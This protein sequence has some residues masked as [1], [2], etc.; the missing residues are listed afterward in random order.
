MSHT[1]I[2][3]YSGLYF[4]FTNPRAED[5]CIEDIARAL[6]MTPRFGGH[7]TSFYSVAEHSVLVR[8]LVIEAGRPDLGLAALLHDAHEAYVGDIPTPLKARVGDLLDDITED[9]DWAICNALGLLSPYQLHSTEVKAGDLL[10]LRHEAAVFKKSRGTG[11]HWSFEHPAVRH[12]FVKGWSP[13]Q[14]EI[15]FLGAYHDEQAQR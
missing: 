9:V 2:E 8:Q 1:V 10:C 5:V 14:A 4:D 12:G 6:S 3:T 7:T 11:E 15:E 13:V